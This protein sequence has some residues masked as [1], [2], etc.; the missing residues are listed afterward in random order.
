AL[1]FR[2]YARAGSAR[3]VQ[4]FTRRRHIRSRPA[5]KSDPSDVG[6]LR[7]LSHHSPANLRL[8][9]PPGPGTRAFTRRGTDRLSYRRRLARHG[10]RMCG[11]LLD[12]AG[13]VSR[14]AGAARRLDDGSASRHSLLEPTLLGRAAGNDRR[15]ARI[16]R[17]AAY[18]A[19]SA[20]AL[21]SADGTG[22]GDPGEQPAV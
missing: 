14:M 9:I 4:Q 19:S 16:R 22:F 21:R 11:D 7:E 10:R 1:T 6:A 2:P 15:R 13:M 18:Y 5:H 17:A 3:R 12:A 20:A 8:K